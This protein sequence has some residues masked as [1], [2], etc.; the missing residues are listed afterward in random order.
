MC[1]ALGSVG[2][3]VEVLD[4]GFGTFRMQAF[5]WQ[6]R[7]VGLCLNRVGCFKGFADICK[8]A[9][10]FLT[11]ALGKLRDFTLD[12]KPAWPHWSHAYVGYTVLQ[13]SCSGNMTI[14]WGGKVSWIKCK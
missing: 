8:G 4:L 6:A 3:K 1:E 14:A 2:L 10:C 5:R 9:L 13:Y 12:G 7:V 11:S